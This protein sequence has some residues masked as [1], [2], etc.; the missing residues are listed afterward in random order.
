MLPPEFS[1]R[2]PEMTEAPLLPGLTATT[3]VGFAPVK[4][5]VPLAVEIVLPLLRM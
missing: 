1:W 2:F 4:V 5:K 3:V